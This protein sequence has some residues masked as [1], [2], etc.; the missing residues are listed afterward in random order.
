[1][2]I[3]YYYECYN[4]K[5]YFDP[6]CL[7]I[8]V[9]TAEY[10]FWLPSHDDF[11]DILSSKSKT[12]LKIIEPLLKQ[13]FGAME[14][15]LSSLETKI[16]KGSVII[17]EELRPVRNSVPEV[18]LL[19]SNN[20]TSCEKFLDET[21]CLC[22]HENAQKIFREKGFL[23]LGVKLIESNVQEVPITAFRTTSI[24]TEE[25]IFSG[26]S[27]K[28][29]AR[30][31]RSTQRFTMITTSITKQANSTA[32]KNDF[33][34]ISAMISTRMSSTKLNQLDCQEI[35]GPKYDQDTPTC[36]IS[37]SLVIPNSSCFKNSGPDKNKGYN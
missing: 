29:F 3:S 12:L 35:I 8:D 13:S 11:N 34:S 30:P 6:K 4:F 20:K 2:E 24:N 23:F 21:N 7:K 9:L 5:A 31:I 28:F 22:W 16:T 25:S 32:K 14:I 10:S 17:V 27:P 33:Q 36:S 37:T 18:K 19:L 26:K 15:N 1:M